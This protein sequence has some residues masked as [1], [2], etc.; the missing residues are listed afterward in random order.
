VE[1]FK[2]K[3][4][5]MRTLKSLVIAAL[6]FAVL[7]IACGPRATPLATPPASP[8]T[9]SPPA[10]SPLPATATAPSGAVI[11]GSVLG[12][13]GAP[14][15]QAT[16]RIQATG[17]ET[18]T[19]DE[20]RFLLS[21]LEA[22]RPVTVSAWK[23]GYYCASEAQ[24]SPPAGGV[25]F[26]MRLVQANDN[27]EYVWV[28]PT[29]K[30]SCY[31][32]KPGVT[33]VWLEND[34]HGR[35]AGNLRFLSM[36][37]GTDVNGGQS[38]ETS[39]GYSRD[40]GRIPLLPNLSKPYYGPGYKLDFPQTAGNCAACHIPGPA[41]DA[42]YAIDPN[43]VSGVDASGIH[44]DFCHKIAD[45]VLDPETGVPYPNMPGVLSMD[46][47]RPFPEDLERYQL[48]FGT[49][50]DDNVPMEDTYLPLIEQSQYC[51]PCHF[52][53]FWD[54]VVYNSFGEW[55]ASRYSDPDFEGARTCQ[56]CHMPSPTMLDGEAIT[57]VAPEAGGVERD[58][59]AI[60]AHT[61][62]G[63]A[64]QELLQ[65]AVTMDVEAHRAAGTIVV[66]V[67]IT[68]DRTG[69]HVPTDSPLRQMI[70]VLDATD[71]SGQPLALVEGT[72]LPDWCGIG[73]PDQGHYAG[74]PGKAYARILQELWTE[75]APT[76]SYWNPTRVLSDTRLAALESDTSS[77]VFSAP[78]PSGAVSLDVRLVFRRAFVQLMEWKGWA[79][80]D[81]EMERQ[82]VTVP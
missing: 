12:P 64:S 44:C 25:T 52:G 2:E 71:G 1:R 23:E 41:I 37:N 26:V 77:Y 28:P 68:N 17:N 78:D 22:G 30:G 8:P 74:L 82:V 54:T 67:T 9:V 56:Q 6:F 19:D 10:A 7:V 40:Y 15:D 4:R 60:H 48:F 24:V 50:D 63:A 38:P 34:A 29:G 62:P 45:V 76:G 5:K 20:G 46:V 39:Y 47:R 18:L 13:D 65:N 59:S 32:C 11:R 73:E 43:A 55:L 69:H 53:V 72:R 70:L 51:A 42:P 49:F 36:Y 57:N 61:F 27:P 31:S 81:I 33:Q 66:N 3:G 80:S 14:L 21:G 79:D 35:S 58:A 75:I 16:V